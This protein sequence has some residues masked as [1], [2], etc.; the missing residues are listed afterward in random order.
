[1]GRCVVRKCDV[2]KPIEVLFN[3]NDKPKATL[4]SSTLWGLIESLQDLYEQN[5]KKGKTDVKA[6]KYA[7]DPEKNPAI[8][9]L[10]DKILGAIF[11]PC[12]CAAKDGIGKCTCEDKLSRVQV[13]LVELDVD[14]LDN[15]L[16][17]FGM[18]QEE[19]GSTKDFFDDVFETVDGQGKKLAK[20]DAVRILAGGKTRKT[21][22]GHS[23]RKGVHDKVIHGKVKAF[24]LRVCFLF[25][26]SVPY[27]IA[28]FSHAPS[29]EPDGTCE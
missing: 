17:G 1:M 16:H 2:A 3:E 12:T 6:F 24:A 23:G 13:E 26:I 10:L 15:D 5:T 28:R 20:P 9:G 21:F 18:S 14:A 22:A 4:Y 25:P 11:V 19:A 29:W 27:S 8:R 7:A